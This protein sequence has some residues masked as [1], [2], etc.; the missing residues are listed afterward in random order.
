MRIRQL[1]RA[2]RDTPLGNAIQAAIERL[3]GGVRELAKDLNITAFSALQGAVQENHQMPQNVLAALQVKADAGL[4]F[5]IQNEIND[6]AT[7]PNLRHWQR[8]FWTEAWSR[9]NPPQ[10]NQ[11]R[12]QQSLLQHACTG[13]GKSDV[14]AMAP[15]AGARERCLVVVPSIVKHHALCPYGAAKQS[16]RSMNTTSGSLSNLTW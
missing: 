9:W 1:F 15:F 13:A 16:P 6:P 5:F 11:P 2:E 8:R 10:W 3:P 14:I 7:I 12:S 4:P